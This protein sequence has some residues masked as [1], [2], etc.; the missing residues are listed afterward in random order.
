MREYVGLFGDYP[1]ETLDQ[2]RM[3]A[4]IDEV[5]DCSASHINPIVSLETYVLLLFRQN[6][7]LLWTQ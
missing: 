4:R 6:V 3:S 7:H 2:L 1:P 5:S